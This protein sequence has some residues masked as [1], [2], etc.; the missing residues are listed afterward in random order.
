MASPGAASDQSMTP[1]TS[2]P[3]TNTWVICRSPWMKTG[4]HGRSAASAISRL[5]RITS[6]GRTALASSHAHS[7][8]SF[9]ATSSSLGPGHGGNGASCS[10]RMAAP[11]AAHAAGDAA[12]GSP[13]RPSALPGT[14]AIAST[15]GSRQ[16]IAG[17]GIGAMAIARTSTSACAGSPSTFRNTS[18]TRSVARWL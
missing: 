14:A 17:V 8:S 3:S 9:A 10:L 4:F 6:A 16:R 2:S 15:G 18:P 13:R 12:D 1:V 11:A 5:R 7:L